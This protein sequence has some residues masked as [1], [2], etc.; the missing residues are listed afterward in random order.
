MYIQEK[1]IVYYDSMAGT[2]TRYLRGALRYLGDEA[3]KLNHTGFVSTDWDLVSM[4]YE[5]PQ[6][7]NGCDCGVFTIMYAD[8]ITDNL[9]LEFSQ[10]QMPLFRNKICANVLRGSMKYSIK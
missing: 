4:G 6:Q 3:T 7:D 1:K 5:V 2:G 10:E 9:P 8:F